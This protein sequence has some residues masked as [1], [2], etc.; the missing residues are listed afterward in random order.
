MPRW[1]AAFLVSLMAVSAG[2]EETGFALSGQVPEFA[3]YNCHAWRDSVA[4]VRTLGEPH[5]ALSLEHG[6]GRLW[7]LDCHN[8]QDMDTLKGGL[9]Y[10][11][12]HRQ[13]ETCHAARVRDWRGGA[14]GR[15]VG[16]WNGQRQILRCTACHD[17]HRPAWRAR[18]PSPPPPR[19]RGEG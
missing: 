11:L 6:G 18:K 12:S 5:D 9:A 2:A 16:G 17:P 10:G 14:H 19:K 1:T 15:R 3:C 4:E 7:C 13:C 8:D